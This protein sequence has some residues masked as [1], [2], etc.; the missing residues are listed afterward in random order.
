[1]LLFAKEPRIEAHELCDWPLQLSHIVFWAECVV[2]NLRERKEGRKK[3]SAVIIN[4]LY[5]PGLQ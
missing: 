4:G 1:M 3:R 5:F 2:G